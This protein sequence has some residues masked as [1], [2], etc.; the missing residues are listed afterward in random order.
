MVKASNSVTIWEDG[1]N[2]GIKH[3]AD[4]WEKLPDRI[5]SLAKRLGVD[6]SLFENSVKGFENFTVQAEKVI[7][8]GVLREV[9]GKEI[10]Y[11]DGKEN[12]KKGIVVIVKGGKI[13]SMMP[14]DPKSFAKLQ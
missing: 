4:Y 3:F 10:Y 13:Q 1:T 2:Q 12:P 7:D 14:S 5:P 9:N 11:L 8:N 6:E